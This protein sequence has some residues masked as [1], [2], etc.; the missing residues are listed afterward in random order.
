MMRSPSP[1]LTYQ[2]NNR[3]TKTGGGPR[4]KTVNSPSTMNT[5]FDNNESLF[6][7]SNISTTRPSTNM[8]YNKAMSLIGQSI[9]STIRHDRGKSFSKS[10]DRFFINSKRGTPSPT[11]YTLPETIGF[12]DSERAAPFK[13]LK[14]SRTVFGKE[15]RSKEFSKQI[16][17]AEIQ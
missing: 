6:Q 11:A 10:K 4:F 8:N 2:S 14:Q 12:N 5:P 9:T 3:S 15:D 16:L 1:T 13:S 7:T 17:S